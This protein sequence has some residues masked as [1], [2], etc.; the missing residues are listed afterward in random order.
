MSERS[1][2]EARYRRLFAAYPKAHRAEREEEMITTLLDVAP[3]GQR[4]PTLRE[5]SSIV[6]NGVACRARSA[7]EWHLGLGLAGLAARALA[8]ALA[9]AA[10]AI[11]L[12]PPVGNPTR[13]RDRGIV[14]QVREWILR[15]IGT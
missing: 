4:R 11:G 3:A 1:D 9:V 14:A 15:I 8:T 13:L 5:A 7:T 10:L 12:L 6:L 2:L